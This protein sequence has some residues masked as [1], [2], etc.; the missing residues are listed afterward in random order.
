MEKDISEHLQCCDK[1]QITKVGKMVPEL[2]SPLPQCTE[3]NQRIHAD[4][5]GPLKTNDGDKKFI[6]CVTDTFTK[7]VELVV[8]PN[9]EAL[10]VATGILNRWICRFGL[11]L[12]IFT[13]Q[14]KEFTNK[15]AEHLF[16]ALHIRHSTTSAY[17]P[18]CNS[19]AEV[20][21]KTIAKYLAAFVDDSTLDW[22]LYVPA[23]MFTYNASY[24]HSVKATPFS[25]TFGL[26]ARLPSFFAPDFRQLYDPELS[27]DNLLA[28]L[29][30]AREKAV[31]N[32]LLATDK[33]EAYFNCSATHHDYH[34]GQFVLLSD[35]SFLNKNC[36]LAPKFSGPFKIL[37][38]KSPH[39]V[40]L[41]LA[42]GRKIVVNVARVKPYFS[43][44]APVI[45]QGDA[46]DSANGSSNVAAE[47]LVPVTS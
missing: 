10:T 3:P 45:S 34:E 30:T 15:M 7:Y 46:N 2:L 6:L 13:D 40:E 39:N 32:N 38:V 37:H 36:K 8:L 31:A 26:E 14:G 35:F 42:N 16:A 25:L 18:Q 21:N 41:L 1:C 47:G 33:Q 29:H 11:P 20:C 12:E 9:K 4:L 17:H 24:H 27:D 5:F 23:M 28:Q 44:T 22:E 19:Q 43:L